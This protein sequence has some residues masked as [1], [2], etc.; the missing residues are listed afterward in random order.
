[1]LPTLKLKEH[2]KQS[3]YISWIRCMPCCI[4]KAPAE[5][6]HVR[7]T[8]TIPYQLAGGT[9]LKPNDLM[10]IPLCRIHHQ[11]AHNEADLESKYNIDLKR[12]LIFYLAKYILE[13]LDNAQDN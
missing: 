7:S 1:M 2:R 11:E 12:E 4:C 9:G 13:R 5:A 6:H 10:S 8:T 3:K